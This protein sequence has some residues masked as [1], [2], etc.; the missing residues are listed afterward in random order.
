M[1]EVFGFNFIRFFALYKKESIRFLKIYH[2][3]IFTPMV[4][5]LLFYLVFTLAFG[6]NAISGSIA[7]KDLIASGLIIMTVLQNS[8]TN[9]SSSLA[10]SKIL[11]FMT[12]YIIS[13]LT[14][15]EILIAHVLCSVTRG[16]ICA[17]SVVVV[18]CLFVNFKIYSAYY[19]IFYLLI[20]S[21][22]FALL[23]LIFG[24]MSSSFDQNHA[25]NTYIIGPL[26]F[27]SGTFYSVA[28]IPQPWQS[29]IKL[30]PVFYMIDGFRYS[31]TGYSDL[32]SH[33]GSVI[34]LTVMLILCFL[35][36][37]V[38]LKKHYV[39]K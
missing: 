5:A 32:T 6:K 35:L 3:T 14:K 28:N 9:T 11:G 8:Y 16:I 33:F 24:A 22:I 19:L 10:M 39:I 37:F 29:I 7:Y 17:I 4:N 1:S 21:A 20:S 30:N 12:D 27:L 36:S 25:Y 13:P 23:G 31:I 38:V 2:Q 15:F 34:F 18:L 26:T